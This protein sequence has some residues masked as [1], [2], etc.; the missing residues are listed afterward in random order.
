MYYDDIKPFAQN[1]DSDSNLIVNIANWESFFAWSVEV[2]HV[3]LQLLVV[4][5]MSNS[6]DSFPL[7]LV[8]NGHH[9]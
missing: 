8:G 4:A 7:P 9:S 6:I 1:V 5:F 2:T 3:W